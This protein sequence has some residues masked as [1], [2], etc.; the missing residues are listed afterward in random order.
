MDHTS[1]PVL[2]PDQASAA[3]ASAT[4]APG[5]WQSRRRRPSGAPPPLPYRLQTSG[6]GWLI[7]AVVLVGLSV[8]VF[9]RGMRGAAVA[10]TVADDAVVRWLSGLRAPGLEGLLQGLARIASWWV[11]LGLWLGVLLALLVLRRWRHLIVWVVVWQLGGIVTGMVVASTAQ[12]PRPF[13]VELRTTWNGWALPSLQITIL[14]ATLMAVLYTLV[15]EGRWR[16]TGKWVVT[17][18]VTLAS[19]ARIALGTDAPTDVLVGAGIA[20]SIPLLMFRRFTPSEVF[21][22]TYRRGRSAHL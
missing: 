21:P 15:P 11:L 19:V 12:R 7:A 13:G 6:V 1:G 10:V 18:L 16:N 5:A 20:V 22:V 8:A 14:T 4:A 9:A 3:P 17:A 2:R